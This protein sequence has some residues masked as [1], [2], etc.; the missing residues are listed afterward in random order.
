MGL[1]ARLSAAQP[2]AGIAARPEAL[3]WGFVALHVA[4]WTILPAIINANPP[5][6]IIEALVMGREWQLGYAKLPPLPWWVVGA[7]SAVDG[8]HIWPIYLVAQLFVAVAFWAVWRLGTAL[9]TPAQALV[10]VAA[11]AGVHYFNFTAHKFNHDVA[12]LPLWALAGWSLWRAL[13]IGRTADWLLFGAWIGLAFWAKY[14]VAVLVA[15]LVLFVLI[16]RDARRSL[17]TPGPWLAVAVAVAIMAPHL[18]WLVAHDFLPLTYAEGRLHAPTGLLDHALNPLRFLVAQLG[19]VAP[20]AGL[21]AAACLPPARSAAPPLERFDRR[22]LAVVALGPL[23]TLLAGSVI[24]GRSLIA[25]WGYPM[26]TFMPLFAVAL[27][28][29]LLDRAAMLRFAIGWGGVFAGMAIAF[30]VAYGVIPRFDDRHRAPDFPGPAFAARV[31]EEWRA[32]TGT[33]LRYA[34]GTMWLAGNVAVYSPDR[35][36]AFVDADASGH[37]WIDLAD[38]RRT[39]GV[40]VYWVDDPISVAPT[41]RPLLERAEQR[42]VIELPL[43]HQSWKIARVGFA[44]IRPERE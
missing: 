1:A 42:P 34:A 44:I 2:R 16:D 41:L 36:R 7:V 25:L 27:I 43:L 8:G 29:P 19:A 14:F 4:A 35:P 6:D 15:P 31:T 13:R 37:P 26:L 24:T 9:L 32:A 3:F 12:Q 39:G 21:I 28:R 30:V 38:F 10:A 40:I 23:A 11:L 5:L 18:W 22:F 17:A 33:P 20:A